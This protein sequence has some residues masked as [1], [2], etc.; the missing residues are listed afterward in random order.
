MPDR[1]VLLGTKG[2]PAVR[3]GGAMPT[4]SFLNLGGR[5][6]VVDCGIGVTR[7]LVEAG[8]SLKDLDLVFVTHL[9]SD[10]VLELGPLL[11]TAWTTGAAGPVTVY[12]PQ[13]TEHYWRHFLAAMEFDGAVRVQDEGRRPIDQIVTVRTYGEGEVMAE[14][15]YRVTAQRVDH[16]PVTECYALR[17]DAAGR[18][19][20]FSA[21]TAYFPPLIRFARGAD[22]LVHEAMLPAGV[23]ALVA[24]TGLGEKLRAHLAASHTTA[25]D[26][27][28]LARAAE[29][30]RLV[31]HH[32]I[33][34]DDPDF[35]E[36][37]WL[38]A[39]STEWRG[40]VT[41]GRDGLEIA[42]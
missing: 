34:A 27:G 33:P 38:D 35:D 28:C 26:A 21:D 11:H 37:D 2:G 42:L 14:S 23:E 32:L 22:L 29:V 17:F 7:A 39:V 19:V 18:S 15:G 1:L 30:R 6:A 8:E 4:A 5:K 25:A 36:Q 16:P 10:H 31:L 24:R 40:P 3:K 20:V 12:G 41:V 13:G 9:H